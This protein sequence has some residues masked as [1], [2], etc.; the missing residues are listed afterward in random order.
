M[1]HEDVYEETPKN[2]ISAGI[3]ALGIAIAIGS[4]SLTSAILPLTHSNNAS[5]AVSTVSTVATIS[6]GTTQTTT[7]P[8]FASGEGSD[9]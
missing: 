5:A 1:N 7:T 8:K 9:D 2:R 6:T 3:I 4:A